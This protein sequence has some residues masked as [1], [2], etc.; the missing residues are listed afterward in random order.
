[1]LNCTCL[2][3][4][5]ISPPIP[6]PLPRFS[7]VSIRLYHRHHGPTTN[8]SYLLRLYCWPFLNFLHHLPQANLS[9]LLLLLPFDK[10]SF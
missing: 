5:K 10:P 4:P 6:T 7:L 3:L 1:M 9:I 8:N 2:L